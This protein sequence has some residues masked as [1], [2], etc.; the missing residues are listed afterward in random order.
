MEPDRRVKDQ[1][2]AGGAE[3]VLKA[4]QATLTNPE[5]DKDAE[6]EM[7]AVWDPAM[8]GAAVAVDVD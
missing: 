8:R 1:V 4:A 5:E 3:T 6:M 7:A 2:E